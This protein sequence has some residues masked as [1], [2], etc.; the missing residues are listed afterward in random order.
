MPALFTGELAPF[1]A[2]AQL[3]LAAGFFAVGWAGGWAGWVGLGATGL[4]VAGL[5]AV[6]VQAAR[7]K[8]VMERA[9]S[10]VLGAPVR[11][12]RLR[13]RRLLWPHPGRP[14][15]V[16]LAPGLSYGPGP[17]QV[18]DRYRLRGQGSPA[19]ALVQMHGGGWTGGK[20]GWQGRPLLHQ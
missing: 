10:A 7:A 20:R 19:P 4:S 16:E 1:H 15:G 12:P 5:A 6:Q 18:A 17:A 8:G 13:L 2:A 14:A 11:L 3:G 9:A